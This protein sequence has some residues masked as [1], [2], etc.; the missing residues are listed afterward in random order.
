MN[1]FCNLW[2]LKYQPKNLDD[3]ILS[4]TNR[5]FFESLKKQGEIPN[6]LFV[7][8]PGIGKSSLAK[9]LVN[10]VL[11]CQFLYVNASDE[12]GIESI[13]GRVKTFAQ[14]RSIDG[15]LKVVI[16]DEADFLSFAS[17]GGGS[18]A[19]AA[20]RNIMEEYS[21]TCR[22]I[23]TANYK[24]KVIPALQSRCQDVNLLP[25]LE[26][27]IAICV[28]I[29]KAESVQ[30]DG[31]EKAKLMDLIKNTYPD[32]RKTLNTLQKCT[33]DGVLSIAK[34]EDRKDFSG[35]VLNKILEKMD[36]VDLRKYIIENETLFHNDY[37]ALLQGLFDSIFETTLA[38]D[39]KRLALIC[40]AEGL[41]RD[42]FVMDKEI[43]AFSCVMQLIDVL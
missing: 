15:K 2:V 35:K 9:I 13:R 30:V 3:L 43:N 8:P 38:P 41:Y 24:H 28:R 33:V 25:P 10:D 27:C 6:L 39:I 16:L 40:V 21:S 34:L 42:A 12:N 29:L 37:H 5:K 26:D 32:L 4:K 23:L 19:Q 11:D 22:W 31:E 7:G 20:L 36:V 14:T 1:T 18:N 17:T